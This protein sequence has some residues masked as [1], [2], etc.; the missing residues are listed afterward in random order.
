MNVQK[1][2]ES[3]S[4]ANYTPVGVID[5]RLIVSGLVKKGTRTLPVPGYIED[6]KFVEVKHSVS[7]TVTAVGVCGDKII[8]SV[9]APR[10]PQG[11]VLLTLDGLSTPFVFPQGKGVNIFPAWS[12][13]SDI[14]GRVM[15]PDQAVKTGIWDA[16]GKLVDVKEGNFIGKIGD[17]LIP[18]EYQDVNLPEGYSLPNARVVS[19]DAIGGAAYLNDKRTGANTNSWVQV[20]STGKFAFL[21]PP[22]QPDARF[23]VQRVTKDGVFA[24]GLWYTVNGTEQAG[25][26]C[27]TDNLQWSN[28]SDLLGAGLDTGSLVI[29]G[30][31]IY[32]RASDGLYKVE[33]WRS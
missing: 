11:G 16:S 7:G 15:G 13:G 2:F 31:V 21:M 30:D 19:G 18:F 26:A 28:V 3:D 25:M 17:Q 6:G 10:K 5:G 8:C 9:V 29:D 27:N 32:G 12:N 33:A 1:I 20:P 22:P 14:L 23:G 4:I 24:F